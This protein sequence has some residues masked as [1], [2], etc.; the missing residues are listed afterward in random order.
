[1][2]GQVGADLALLGALADDVGHVAVLAAADGDLHAAEAPAHV[3]G[4]AGEVACRP[5]AEGAFEGKLIVLVVRRVRLVELAQDV[6]TV[7]L[8]LVGGIRHVVA[9]GA[10]VRGRVVGRLQPVVPAEAAQ[11]ERAASPVERIDHEVSAVLA[12]GRMGQARED[13]GVHG[14]THA[15]LVVRVHHAMAH[16]AVHA[17]E[18]F[19]DQRRAIGRGAA[20]GKPAAGRVASQAHVAR[21]G[22]VLLGDGQRGPQHRIASGLGHHARRPWLIGLVQG[23]VSTMA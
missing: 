21:K 4:A 1:M 14:R 22:R 15:G 6:S 20:A 11:I 9:R 3:D 18:V 5:F 13:V 10:V 19:G 2:R 7:G 8:T 17:V 12:H 16:V 23:V